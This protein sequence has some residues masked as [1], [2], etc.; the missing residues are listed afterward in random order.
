MLRAVAQ[1]VSENPQLPCQDSVC[2]GGGGH[3]TSQHDDRA[4]T[5]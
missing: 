1:Q 2:V 4:D 5:L 3:Y